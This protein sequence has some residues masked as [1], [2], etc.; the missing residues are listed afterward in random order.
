MLFPGAENL[1]GQEGLA[2]CLSP[3]A[4]EHTKLDLKMNVF[5]LGKKTWRLC[6]HQNIWSET[7]IDVQS[8]NTVGYLR[9]KRQGRGQQNPCLSGSEKQTIKKVIA[10]HTS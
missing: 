4:C 9:Y 2:H 1:R 10:T 3:Q 6:G 5:H 8:S 7:K